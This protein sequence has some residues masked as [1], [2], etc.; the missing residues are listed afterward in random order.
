MVAELIFASLLVEQYLDL[1]EEF[2]YLHRN[3]IAINSS[4]IIII[5]VVVDDFLPSLCHRRPL[6]DQD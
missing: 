1:A 6:E 5:V 3:P 4:D 2:A